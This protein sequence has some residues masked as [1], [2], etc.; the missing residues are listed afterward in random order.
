MTSNDYGTRSLKKDVCN[1]FP[2]F[3]KISSSTSQ[4]YLPPQQ[5]N[6]HN[7]VT[8]KPRTLCSFIDLNVG[9]FAYILSLIFNINGLIDQTLGLEIS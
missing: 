1:I 4:K 7:L 5:Y 8:L 9:I 3:S 6:I 2:L